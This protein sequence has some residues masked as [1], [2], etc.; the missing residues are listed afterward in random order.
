MSFNLKSPFQQL[1][2]CSHCHPGGK[3]AISQ[4]HYTPEP[5]GHQPE[6]EPTTATH[7]EDR[8]RG[9]R[10][11]QI[12]QRVCVCVGDWWGGRTRQLVDV[13]A[14]LL[15]AIVSLCLLQTAVT[16]L[17]PHNWAVNQRAPDWL[18]NKKKT[19]NKTKTSQ[20][21]SCCLQANKKRCLS[22]DWSESRQHVSSTAES[23]ALKD[24]L[25]QLTLSEALQSCD[26][27]PT[28]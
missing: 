9:E 5:N 11:T 14:G 23:R 18:L 28:P 20:P 15:V 1:A 16:Q 7:N 21:R 4:R 12:N 19:Q 27:L 8:T 17:R 6:R 2:Q 26:L 25:R 24:R 13:K 3:D 10:E 22:C